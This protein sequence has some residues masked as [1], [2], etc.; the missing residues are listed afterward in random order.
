[1]FFDFETR[2][3]LDMKTSTNKT[4]SYNIMDAL[5]CVYF[6]NYKSDVWESKIFVTNKINSS[7]R[8]FLNFLRD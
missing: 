6:K 7:A 4:T 5:C 1:M 8:Q 2:K 3:L